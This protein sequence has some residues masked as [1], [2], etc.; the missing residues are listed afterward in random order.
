MEA[1][2]VGGSSVVEFSLP[3]GAVDVVGSI[4][5]TVTRNSKKKFLSCGFG[6]R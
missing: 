1:V 4:R 6:L 2:L 5:L 3:D